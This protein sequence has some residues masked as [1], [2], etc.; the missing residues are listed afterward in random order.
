M[1]NT[2]EKQPYESFMIGASIYDVAEVGEGITLLLSTA[3]AIDRDGTDV[4]AT[5]LDQATLA[6]ASDD[7]GG[8][9]NVLTIRLRA[10]SDAGTPYKITFKMETDLGNKYEVDVT[11]NVEEK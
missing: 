9:D 5:L 1:A 8:L 4:S 2:I 3:T 6:L 10:G 11:A 7:Q